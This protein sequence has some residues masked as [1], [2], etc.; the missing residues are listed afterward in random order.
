MMLPVVGIV[1]PMLEAIYRIGIERG[2]KKAGHQR[3]FVFD[4]LLK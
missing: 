3:K 2:L 4:D 1:S